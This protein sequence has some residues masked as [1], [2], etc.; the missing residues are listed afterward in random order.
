M[1]LAVLVEVQQRP[2]LAQ[3]DHARLPAVTLVVAE[4][5]IR[6]LHPISQREVLGRWLGRARSRCC[7]PAGS[8]ALAL[9]ACCQT[10]G[11][12]AHR[13]DLVR[14]RARARVRARVRA[15]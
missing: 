7:L 14:A 12:V 10:A 5:R 1:L 8:G 13:R 6:H 11:G 3:R 15:R 2:I 4:D 9:D